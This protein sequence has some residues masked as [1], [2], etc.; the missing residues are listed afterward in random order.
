[1]LTHAYLREHLH[2]SIITGKFYWLKPTTNII[3]V[4]DVAGSFDDK[5]YR[6]IRINRKKHLTH[7]L[8]WFWVIGEWPENNIDHVSGVRDA[9]YWLNIREATVSQNNCNVGLKPANTSGYKGVSWHKASQ[10]WRAQIRHNS[11]PKHLGSFV[12]IEEA[13]FERLK[14]EKELHGEFARAI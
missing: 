5:G 11:K 8:A 14:A 6:F 13:Y 3:Q 12:D 7:R 1:M 9:N 4:G 2:Y 10:K